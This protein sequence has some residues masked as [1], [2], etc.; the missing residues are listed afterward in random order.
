METTG[1]SSAPSPREFVLAA[2]QDRF[3]KVRNLGISTITFKVAGEDSSEL[4]IAEN[5]MRAK[6]G[7]ARHIHY[8]QDE[9][10]FVRRGEFIIEVGQE[11]H[12]LRPGDSVWGPRGIPHTWA[13]TSEG[14]GSI[15]FVFNPAAKIEAFFEAIAKLNSPAPSESQFWGPYEMEWVGPP[16]QV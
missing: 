13:Y 14:E 15:L 10:F 8:T 12:V 11:R 7:P 3:A 1:K 16:L 6:G 9:W 2:S 5:L 4:F